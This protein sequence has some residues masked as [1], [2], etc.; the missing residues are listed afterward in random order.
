MPLIKCADCGRDISDQ[1]PACPHCGRPAAA[2]K[3]VSSSAAPTP[4]TAKTSPA[5][6][7][8]L[9]II[10]LFVIFAILSGS[11][12]DGGSN[13]SKSAPTSVDLSA[14]VRFTG[15]QFAITNNDSFDWQNCKLE[16][17]PRTFSSGFT[18]NAASLRAGHEYS[19]GALQFANGDGKRF[20]PI[21]FKPTS[22][23][24]SCDTQRGRGYYY[25]SWK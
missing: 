18:Y 5:A 10:V 8:C 12:S 21:E 17:N 24:I 15:L 13:S 1:A 16:V 7:G 23:A 25:G 3:Q 9:A 4:E 19:V 20:N 2:E 6:W 11:G 22:I 14:V